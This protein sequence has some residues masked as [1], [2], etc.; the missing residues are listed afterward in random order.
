MPSKS[1]FKATGALANES[2]APTFM[3]LPTGIEPLGSDIGEATFAP[4]MLTAVYRIAEL[5][6]VTPFA[7]TGIMLLMARGAKITNPVLNEAGDPKLSFSP[8]PGL[9]LQGGAEMRIWKRI[10]ARL[11][12]KYVLGMK[13]NAKIENIAVTPKAIPALGSIEVGDAVLS[14]KVTPLVVQLAVG[15]DF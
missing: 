4:P 6:P 13:V 3:G 11:D 15:A 7:G 10:S 14:A 12:V 8:S 2:L 1:K 9:V 5:G